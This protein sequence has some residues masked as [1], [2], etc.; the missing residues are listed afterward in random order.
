MTEI[1]PATGRARGWI[2]LDRGQQRSMPLFFRLSAGDGL[3]VLVNTLLEE[4]PDLLARA[5]G[6]SPQALIAGWVSAV[7]AQLAD[8]LC[9]GLGPPTISAASLP[10]EHRAAIEVLL[11]EL[12]ATAVHQAITGS[13]SPQDRGRVPDD[14]LATLLLALPDAALSPRCRA[15]L[16]GVRDPAQ[17]GPLLAEEIAALRQQMAMLRQWQDGL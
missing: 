17:L 4:A 14:V 1:D 6:E 3:G 12:R 15:A 5:T 9:H 8:R 7:E 13:R 2:V 16:A 11:A 10:P